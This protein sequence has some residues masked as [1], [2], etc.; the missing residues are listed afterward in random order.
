MQVKIIIEKEPKRFFKK[1]Y[2]RFIVNKYN[3]I[4]KK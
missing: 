3:A 2:K 1:S 4:Q